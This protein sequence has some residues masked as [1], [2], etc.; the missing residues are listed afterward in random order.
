[1]TKWVS[2]KHSIPSI[3]INKVGTHFPS[4]EILT[5]DAWKR[6]RV[7]RFVRLKNGKEYYIHLN[8]GEKFSTVVT[9]WAELPEPPEVE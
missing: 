6:I 2:V 4:R 7:A 8:N 5:C 9:H 3:E 1:M